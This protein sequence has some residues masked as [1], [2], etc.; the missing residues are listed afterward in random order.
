MSGQSLSSL[1]SI[2]LCLRDIVCEPADAFHNGSLS[3]LALLLPPLVQHIAVHILCVKHRIRHTKAHRQRIH[4]QHQPRQR[5]I[6]EVPDIADGPYWERR[7]LPTAVILKQLW[8]QEEDLGCERGA[9][10]GA[11]SVQ[12]RRDPLSSL[13]CRCIGAVPAF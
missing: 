13:S 4:Q 9:A 2:T 12:I 7:A 11:R 8:D 3:P 5:R 10:E 1:T 6:Y